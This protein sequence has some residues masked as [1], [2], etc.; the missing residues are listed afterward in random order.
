MLEF[1]PDTIG[2]NLDSLELAVS[3]LEN[4][5]AVLAEKVSDLENA[6][7]SNQV[8]ILRTIGSSSVI[9]ILFIVERIVSYKTSNKLR[10]RRFYQEIIIKPNVSLAIVFFSNF[11]ESLE[12]CI[13]ELKEFNGNPDDLFK[14]RQELLDELKN[15]KRSFDVNF[16][17]LI[18]GVA[19][20]K[21]TRMSEILNKLEDVATN[22]IQA[23]DLS[24]LK[25]NIIELEVHNVK[26]EF[27]AIIHD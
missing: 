10:K 4:A 21:A 12:K 9:I 17:S 27:F 18:R 13:Q 24:N 14:L 7:N 8:N 22:C 20:E 15:E 1:E 16:I 26:A 11:F 23:H 5:T 6:S 25:L 2:V 19:R 3:H